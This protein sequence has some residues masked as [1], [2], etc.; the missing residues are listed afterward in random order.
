MELRQLEAFVEAARRGSISR[1]AQTLYLTQPSLT[2]RVRALE[3]EV[4][5]QLLVRSRQGVRLTPAGRLFLPRA[6]TALAA[7]RRG[8]SELKEMREATGGGLALTAAPDVAGYALPAALGRFTREHP[9]VDVFLN[10]A[11]SL[12]AATAVLTDEAELAL[13]NRPVD[14][15]HL[16]GTALYEERLLPVAAPSHP[17]AAA[18]RVS[19]D[20]FAGA[21]LVMRGPAT[22]IHDLTMAVM[23][24]S[25][26]VPRVVARA[27]STDTMRRL[28]SA[29]F[30]VGLLPELSVRDD[31]AAGRL[32][33]LSIDGARPKSRAI[34]ALQREGS[35][36]SGAV[37]ALLDTLRAELPHAR[38]QRRQP[39]PASRSPALTS[40]PA[41]GPQPLATVKAQR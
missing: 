37:R 20:A 22:H 32:T 15:P 36:P 21:G 18:E 34:V 41:A 27:D 4:G 12:A 23:G 24:G 25:G 9:G 1:A 8:E 16:R 38:G 28:L 35:Q 11:N 17:L 29:G 7:L 5:Q 14:F 31:L 2:Q 6:E 40:R 3:Q 26:I 19:V 13:V 10:V 39:A 30:G 33:L